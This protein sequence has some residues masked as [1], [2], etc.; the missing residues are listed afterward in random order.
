MALIRKRELASLT[1]DE[2]TKKANDL[3]L[4]LLK[5]NAVKASKTAPKKIREI[6]RTV[7]RILTA[8]N[9]I[10]KNSEKKTQR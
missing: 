9:R 5:A 8:M 4:E 10:N 2:L 7:A 6:K 3:K 1:K